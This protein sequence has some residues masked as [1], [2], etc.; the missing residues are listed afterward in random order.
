MF[1]VLQTFVYI[2]ILFSFHVFLKL[3]RQAC[4]SCPKSVNFCI[5]IYSNQINIMESPRFFR[6]FSL[7][8]K[9]SNYFCSSPFLC[10]WENKHKN[11]FKLVVSPQLVKKCRYSFLMFAIHTLYFA[12]QAYISWKLKD[13]SS[14]CFA[15][16]FL[17]VGLNLV[18]TLFF[19]VFEPEQYAATVNLQNEYFSIFQSKFYAKNI[20]IV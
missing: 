4:F 6:M 8:L 2:E 1:Y 9:V 13:L 7:A 17:A 20:F 16:F 19:F 18:T 5:I 3:T 14:F 15:T 11:N 10:K 12:M